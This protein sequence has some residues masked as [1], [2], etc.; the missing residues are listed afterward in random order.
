MRRVPRA[1][2]IGIVSTLVVLGLATTSA[3]ASGP[4]TVKWYTAPQPGGSFAAAAAACT[5]AAN[6]KYRIDLVPLP[7]DASVQREQLVRR[8]AAEDSDIDLISMDVIWTAEFAEPSGS[9][10]GRSDDRR[11]GRGGRHPGRARDGP[12]QEPDVRG[13]AQHG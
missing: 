12:L 8:L 5:K 3:G 10:R 2:A 7:S 4:V 6:G 1:V 11:E 9:C 13:A